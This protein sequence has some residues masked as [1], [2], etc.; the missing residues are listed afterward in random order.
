MTNLE[1]DEAIN[2]LYVQT[3]NYQVQGKKAYKP[4]LENIIA[5]CDFFGNPQENLKMVHIAG[6]N[7][8]GSTCN[9]LA[10]VLQN[11]GYKVGLYTSPHLINFTERIK[12]NG[13]N[14]TE[15]FV[16]EFINKL[17]QLP[18]SIKPSFFEFTT[19][20][21]FEYF[22]QNNV[23]IAIIEVGLGGRLDSTNIIS[24]LVSAITNVDLDHQN[25]LG[26]TIEEIAREKAGIIKP[27]IPVIIGEEKIVVRNIL[28]TTAKQI[29]ARLI[30]AIPIECDFETDLKGNY[31]KKNLKVV[32]GLITE[33]QK[34]GFTISSKNL[35]N[36]L[37]SVQ[38]STGFMGRWHQISEKPLII[39]DT[40]H[41]F[42]GM[43]E[44]LQQLESINKGKHLVLGFVQD[45][46]LTKLL[47]I[48]PK[49]F[50]YY[51]VKP[52][53]ERG[54]NPEEY[55]AELK[56]HKL[57]YKIFE[58]SFSGYLSAKQTIKENE[59]L[60]FGGSNFVV[61]EILENILEN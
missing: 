4:G 21:A 56:N 55:E 33:L 15:A 36:G 1:Y 25:I 19:V 32:L 14:A 27:N 37:S 59:M 8:K 43:Q 28:E 61:A 22:R 35:K 11:A 52:Y 54:R 39:C 31:Q 40:A 24:P 17:K 44:V 34:N 5:L 50:Y 16:F 13:E 6:T 30:D 47:E 46:E 26:N 51:F 49:E 18:E 3:P 53:L 60:F 29:G 23:D 42:A 7:G 41:N 20:M 10:S 58:N 12:I 57:N 45:K 38:K 9:M 2:W 48:L